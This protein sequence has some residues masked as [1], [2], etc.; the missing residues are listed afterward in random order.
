[1]PIDVPFITLPD[2]LLSGEG[3]LDPLGLSSVGDKLADQIL[4]GLRARMSR[5]RFVTAM[6]V[7]AAVCDGLEEQVA[8]DRVTPASIVF[9]WFLVDGFARAESRDLVRR[10]PG[11]DKARSAR[12]AGLHLSART[13][14]KTPSVFGFHGVYKSLARHLGIVDEDLRLGENGHV[15][16]DTWEREQG[17]SGFIERATG[18]QNGNDLRA[19]LRAAVDDAMRD[20]YAARS[21]GWQGWAFFLEHL[22]P[23]SIGAK[24][25]A[26]LDRLLKDPKGGTRGEVFTLVGNGGQ[27]DL[28][29]SSIVANIAPRASEELRARLARIQAYERFC[30]HVETSF[31]WLRWLSSSSG[32]TAVGPAHFAAVEDVQRLAAGLGG[33]KAA[34]ER[35]LPASPVAVQ[36]EFDELADYFQ[37]CSTPEQLFHCLMCRHA[38][39][40]KQK[41]PDGKREWFEHGTDDKVM[42]RIPYRVAEQPQP[43]PAWPRPYR[44]NTV[45]QFS[46]DLRRSLHG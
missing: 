21:P 28:P 6:A 29:E 43:S 7:G 32:A 27:E 46:S 24:E 15:L 26:L 25:A 36:T 13:Y 17:V 35:T 19:T 11:I 37:D 41:P 44:L 16:L 8:A 42:I 12:Q 33:A 10:T 3:A 39:V 20:G 5:V 38:D 31:E 9:E 2:P 18:L 22:L 4:P 40:Q 34:V 1:M 23:S 30:S 45:R 14:L